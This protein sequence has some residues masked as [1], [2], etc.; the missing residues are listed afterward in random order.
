[1][2]RKEGEN[3]KELAN[4]STN[5]DLIEFAKEQCEIFP[6]DSYMGEYL[7]ETIKILQAEPCEDAISRQAVLD[8]T[9]LWSKDEFLRVTNPF[10]YLHKRINSLPPV[11]PTRKKGKWIKEY[12][13]SALD[14]LYHCSVCGRK[15]WIY[16]EELVSDYPYCHCG[17]RNE[18]E[19]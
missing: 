8:Q 3:M 16:K 13:N 10:H 4:N 19:E 11:A 6:E 14:G 15:L 9:Y 2:E 7:R 18:V 17:S 5:E 12:D 1:M